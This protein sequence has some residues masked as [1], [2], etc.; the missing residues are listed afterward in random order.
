MIEE[1]F[2]IVRDKNGEKIAEF[3]NKTIASE[4]S[5]KNNLM[6][7]P[8]I[9]IVSNG[10]STLT[11]QMLI[12]SDKWQQ[13]KH[14]EN[15]YYCNGRV[16][17]A[18]NEQSYVYNGEVV[19]V[20]LVE[21]WYLLKYV[22]LQAH[23]VDT[24]VE[25]LD[26]HT[27]K[28]LPRTESKF[29]MTINGTAYDDSVIKD[30]RGVL[31]PRG[32]AG[33]ALWGILKGTDWSLGVCDVLPD[34][35]NASEDYGTFNVETDMKSAYENIAYIQQLYGGILDWDSENKILSLRDEAKD[36][37]DFNTWK[38]YSVRKDKNL[39]ELPTIT[40]DN[41]I[42][43]RLYPLGNGNLNIKAVNDGKGYVDNFSYSTDIYEAY[44]SNTNIYDTN[45]TGGQKTLKYWAEKELEKLCK[46]RKSISY[47]IVDV[48]GNP[49]YAYEKF[50]VNDIVKCYYQDTD[51]GEEIYEYLRIQH[52]SYNWFNPSSDSTIEVGDKVANEI[53]LF[54]QLYNSD[55][56]LSSTVSSYSSAI[57][58]LI[59][60]F[61]ME[62][63]DSGTTY[64]S[65][66]GFESFAD[67][68]VATS[69]MYA[70]F[71]TDTSD[72]LAEI[73]ATADATSSSID[74]VSSFVGYEYDED[75]N[76]V[77]TGTAE[78]GFSQLCT[79]VA[80]SQELTTKFLTEDSEALTSIKQNSDKTSSS[81]DAIASFVGGTKDNNGVWHS[82]TSST[83]FNSF[84][85]SIA[86]SASMKSSFIGGYTD[87]DGVWHST[88]SEAGFESFCNSIKATSRMYAENDKYVAEVSAEADEWNRDSNISL[89]V[90]KATDDDRT[91][92]YSGFYVGFGDSVDYRLAM[93][94]D[95]TRVFSIDNNAV[96]SIGCNRGSFDIDYASSSNNRTYLYG[97]IYIAS[98]N[99][100]KGYL[101]VPDDTHLYIGGKTI[102]Q[103][104]AENTPL[105]SD[106][107]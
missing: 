3:S 64:I 72:A 13:I 77:W 85:N 23:N 2:V 98:T 5:A 20:T 105:S 53:E 36:G 99:G 93:Y 80:A 21:R 31:M 57:D 104:V 18:L 68:T 100:E 101:I 67:S 27:V 91:K 8:T 78:T 70:Q 41:N 32:S 43:T 73:T 90:Y 17:T 75:G 58:A 15:L 106:Y 48:R 33:Y 88:T 49:D 46:P 89:G 37:T 24:D 39:S 35:F 82:S 44:V 55:S 94:H 62:K 95:G 84:C 79:A 81:I 54:H 74:M 103:Y 19:T 7:A 12:N 59:D 60:I 50:D 52:L 1:R 97:G 92:P 26:D 71:Q 16:Y 69:T 40:W 25:A 56:D 30:S 6:F 4:S 65:K 47:S 102:K 38:G 96:M 66:A 11:F 29:K 10:E 9:N 28:I 76:L 45:D 14:P 42:T 83:A 86:A 87:D 63:S 22:F 51:T 107:D 61:S 34:G